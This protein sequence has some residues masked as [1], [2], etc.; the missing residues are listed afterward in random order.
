MDTKDK[1]EL[2]YYGQNPDKMGFSDLEKVELSKGCDLDYIFEKEIEKGRRVPE[3]FK[4]HRGS[5]IDTP[6]LY[7]SHKCNCHE[8][9]SFGRDW[10]TRKFG[11]ID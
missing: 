2:E 4:R 9:S 8:Y 3:N 6:P 1:K 7:C 10:E 5:F 11:E